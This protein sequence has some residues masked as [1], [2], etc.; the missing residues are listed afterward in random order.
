MGHYFF[1]GLNFIIKKCYTCLHKNITSFIIGIHRSFIMKYRKLGKNND[2]VSVLGFGC[3]RFPIIDNDVS[4]IDE[5]KATELLRYAIDNGVNYIDTAHI[6][7][8]EQ[9][10]PFLGRALGDGYRE[11]IKLATKLPSWLINSKADMY[12]YLDGQLEK[13]QTDYIDF[14]LIHS[15]NTDHWA[16]V[17][18]HDVFGFIENSLKSGKIKN[19]GFSFHD[20]LPLFKEITDSY[21]WGFAQIQLNYMDE[22]YQAGL[23]GLKYLASKGIDAVIME[24]LRGGRLAK[25]MSDDIMD[26]W[27]ASEK[28]RNPAAWALHY[29]WNY[30]EVAILLSGM[31]EMYEVVENIKE[32]SR[33]K[34]NS[35]TEAENKTIASVRDILTE[36]TVVNCTG[37]NY[38]MPCP[39]NVD[40]PKNFSFLNVSAMYQET[41]ITKASYLLNIKE[42]AQSTKCV[43]CGKC[44]SECP[45]NIEI[46]K[47]LKEV[48]NTFNLK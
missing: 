42:P 47:M 9:S 37:C 17:K 30:P 29:V 33:S 24:P 35:L 3:M 34:A 23:E 21:D 22:D 7:H 11:K 15:L 13:L 1:N 14:Y 44:E 38:C 27:N 6:Y 4:K 41:K 8:G 40:I 19:I 16:R 25:N 31:G 39:S 28:K 20:E 5:V 48:T 26:I 10:E 43:E 32:A 18:E 12:K 45:Q 2:M 36:R 46:I